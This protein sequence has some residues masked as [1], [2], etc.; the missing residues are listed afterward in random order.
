L[1]QILLQDPDLML[2]GEPTNHLDLEGVEL[3]S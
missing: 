3:A 2:L 1:A